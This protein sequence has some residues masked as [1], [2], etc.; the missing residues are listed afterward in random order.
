MSAVDGLVNKYQKKVQQLKIKFYTDLGKLQIE[1][2]HEKTHWMQEIRAD[3][4]CDKDLSKRCFICGS[5]IETLEVID[6]FKEQL[7]DK[8]DAEVELK[9]LS[10]ATEKTKP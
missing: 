3:G 1:C 10:L 5:T 4:S 9:K 2:K 6:S 8:F 7:L